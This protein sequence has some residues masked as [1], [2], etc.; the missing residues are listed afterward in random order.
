MGVIVD[1]LSSTASNHNGFP[2]VE[3][4]DDTQVPGPGRGDLGWVLSPRSQG[5]QVSSCLSHLTGKPSSSLCTYP[6]GYVGQ[7]WVV[8]T[9]RPRVWDCGRIPL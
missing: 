5:P 3:S 1:V 4:T 6:T 2:V 7:V 8:G 9:E